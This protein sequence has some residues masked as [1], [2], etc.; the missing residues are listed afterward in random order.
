LG[1]NSPTKRLFNQKNAT[2][3]TVVTNVA[4]FKMEDVVFNLGAEIFFFLEETP[5]ENI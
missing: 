4:F 2:F 3:V 5:F 1:K